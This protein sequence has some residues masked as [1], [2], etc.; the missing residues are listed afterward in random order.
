M[1]EDRER[2]RNPPCYL[3]D[4][5]KDPRPGRKLGHVTVVTDDPAER[6]KILEKLAKSLNP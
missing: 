4:Y 3:H 2:F 6:D 5:G 1:P